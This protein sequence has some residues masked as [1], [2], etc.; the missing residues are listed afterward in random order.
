VFWDSHKSVQ[1]RPENRRSVSVGAAGGVCERH[2]YAE[3]RVP[4]PHGPP[5]SPGAVAAQRKVAAACQ[6]SRK[7]L[8]ETLAKPGTLP[9]IVLP[10]SGGYWVD[11]VDDAPDGEEAEPRAQ[12]GTPRQASRRNNIDTDDT[13]KYYRRFF[14]GK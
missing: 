9:T 2:S 10:P 5:P 13:A 3:G 6:A 1:V 8:E 14:L 4:A 11:G 7:L 12:P